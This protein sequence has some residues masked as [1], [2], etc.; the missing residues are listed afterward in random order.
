MV[1]IYLLMVNIY[2]S[3]IY[4]YLAIYIYILALHLK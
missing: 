4:K 3:V 2:K 1:I